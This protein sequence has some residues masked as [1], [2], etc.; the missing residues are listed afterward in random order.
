MTLASGLTK[1]E[2]KMPRKTREMRDFRH[3]DDDVIPGYEDLNIGHRAVNDFASLCA[4]SGHVFRFWQ[5]VVSDKDWAGIGTV[6]MVGNP[7]S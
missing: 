5:Y 6:C 2:V 7:K 1:T 3:K 4:L